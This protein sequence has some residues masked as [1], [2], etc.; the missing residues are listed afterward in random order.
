MHFC[1]LRNGSFSFEFVRD[2]K[3][4]LYAFPLSYWTAS[5][6]QLVLYFI[7]FYVAL[8]ISS[9]GVEYPADWFTLLI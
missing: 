6:A 7:G 8:G 2:T 3:T 1:T 9:G 4:E 5:T